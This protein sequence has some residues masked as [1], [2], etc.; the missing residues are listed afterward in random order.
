MKCPPKKKCQKMASDFHTHH[1]HPGRR[2]LI[3]NGKGKGPLWSLS[4]HPWTTAVFPEISA[5]DLDSCAALGEVGYDKFKGA[6]PYPEVQTALFKQFLALAFEHKKSVVLHTVG[7]FELLFEAVK[8]FQGLSMLVHGFS[9]HNPAL[10][11]QLLDRGFF[12]SLHPSLITDEKIICFL[13][14][15]PGCRAGLETD[16]DPDLDIETLY[17]S[18]PVPGFEEAA[19]RHFEE[20]LHL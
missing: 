6:A 1:V 20:F 7:S 4:F 14:N 11:G 9:K 3:D 13:Q 8:P 2:E 10:L 5:E 17:R 15:H 18:I 12:V 19:D 16:D